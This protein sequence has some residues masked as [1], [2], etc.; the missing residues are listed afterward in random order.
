MKKIYFLP[1]LVLS[2]FASAQQPIEANQPYNFHKYISI[3]KYTTANKPT[4]ASCPRCIIYNTDSS[5]FAFSTGSTWLYYGSGGGGSNAVNWGHIGGNLPDQADLM[6][7]LNAKMNYTDTTSLV[8][9]YLRAML[10]VKYTDTVAML[11]PYLLSMLGIKYSDSGGMLAPYLK[12]VN[13]TKAGIG[14]GSVTNSLQVIN[15][16]GMA[17]MA[18][19][20]F[21]TIPAAASGPTMY[22]ATDTLAWY[23]NDGSAYHKMAGGTGGGGGG[24]YDSTLMLSVFAAK[25]TYLRIDSF[26]SPGIIRV[27]GFTPYSSTNPAGYITGN[28]SIAVTGTGDVTGTGTGSTSISIPFVIGANKVAYSQFQQN[29][30]KSLIGNSQAG[31]ANNRAIFPRSGLIWDADSL[32]ADTALIETRFDAG[33]MLKMIDVRTSNP[34]AIPSGAGTRFMWVPSLGAFRAGSVTG[35]NWD[36]ANLGAHSTAIGTDNLAA[37]QGSAAFGDTNVISS[38]AVNSVAMGLKNNIIGANQGIALGTGNTVSG[39]SATAIGINGRVLGAAAAT[40]G[41]NNSAVGNYSYA[42]GNNLTSKFD[43]QTFLGRFNDS[44]NGALLFGIGYGLNNTTRRNVFTVDSFGNA[45][46]IGLPSLSDSSNQLVSSKWVKQQLYGQ[47][48]TLQTLTFGTGLILGT[49]NGG[50]A[51]TAKVDTGSMTTILSRNKL[52]DTL[53]TIIATK[54]AGTLS[55]ISPLD[56]LSRVTAGLQVIGN[57]IVPQTANAS[58]PGLMT[59]AQWLL[60]DS[61]SRRIFRSKISLGHSGAGLWSGYSS[62][63]GDSLYFKNI[64]SSADLTVSSPSD[65]SLL[66][67]INFTTVAGV[68]TAQTLTN[69]TLTAPILNFGSDVTGNM[70]YR[71]GGGT[72]GLIAPGSNG[73]ALRWASGVPV[74]K[75]TVV[76]T[77]GGSQNLSQ[78]LSAFADTIKISGGTGTTILGATHSNAGLMTAAM[79]SRGDSIVS[80]FHSGHGRFIFRAPYT[81]DSLIDL[82]LG[83]TGHNG[84]GV[85][86]T[87]NKDSLSWD[88][89]F[90]LFTTAGDQMIGGAAGVP[91][92]VAAGAD[93]KIWTMVSGSPAW[94]TAPSGSVTSVSSGNFGPLFTAAFSNPNTTPALAF[95][96]SNAPAHSFLGNFTGATGAYSFS[97]PIL[98]SADFANQGAVGW[99][100]HGN[101]AGNPSWSPVSMTTDVTGLLQ[102]AQFPALLGAISTLPGSLTTTLGNAV[103]GTSN[104]AVGAVSLSTQVGGVLPSTNG[105]TQINNGGRTIQVAGNFATAGAFPLTLTTTAS[106]N[107]TFPTTGTLLATNGSGAGLSG[108]AISATGTANQVL[109]NG[110]TGTPQTG[111]LTFT[112]PQ[113][114]GVG[115]A[116]TFTGMTLTGVGAGA[117]TDNILTV[118]G[119]VLRSLPLSGLNAFSGQY[120]PTVITN[121]GGLT[122]TFDTSLYIRV[123]NTVTIGGSASITSTSS[124]VYPIH[125]SLP[126]ASNLVNHDGIGTISSGGIVTGVLG[127]SSADHTGFINLSVSTAATTVFAYTYIYLIH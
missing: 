6:N 98:A 12:I 72:I 10:G 121:P 82:G 16:G 74:W 51:F 70:Y 38:A 21:A 76:A 34:G 29:V 91:T 122:I 86:Y 73:Q 116:P 63:L 107:V 108:I 89:T 127:T 120:T 64:Q 75:D 48:T 47:G 44:T 1:V 42:I 43:F 115:N 14:L 55:R 18:K 92:R 17:S 113:P 54:G 87:G 22:F 24:G 4:A 103:V 26:S 102:A 84:I 32:K 53:L 123:G 104:I 49:Y 118:S 35:S 111:A 11:S 77:G 60:S 109:V 126:F 94:A 95:T 81:L 36:F 68:T 114:L 96:M 112:L 41:L 50:S 71:T 110:T 119:G 52:R 79:Q 61:I 33:L 100:L 20:T 125:F 13:F 80:L 28:Q 15:S 9:P 5:N 19:G 57:T 45:I 85:S 69:K 105:G 66:F 27:L 23:Y 67:G 46:A 83:F 8:A 106:T 97:N 37:A 101:T 88:M 56:S 40:I 39:G 25:S 124:G 93:G 62:P 59:P 117:S 30:A 7:R 31:T 99:V 65:S 58:F 3:G 90:N 2:L 78:S